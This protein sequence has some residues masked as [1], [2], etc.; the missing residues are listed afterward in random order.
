MSRFGNILQTQI[1]RQVLGDEH[2]GGIHAGFVDGAGVKH[3]RIIRLVVFTHQPLDF[4]GAY[5]VC[6]HPLIVI[7]ARHPCSV[8]KQQL[9]QFLFSAFCPLRNP[10]RLFLSTQL[11]I[12]QAI[13]R[14]PGQYCTCLFIDYP[15]GMK[16]D[17]TYGQGRPSPIFLGI[18]RLNSCF[19][20]IASI[21]FLFFS[22][23]STNSNPTL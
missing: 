11:P 10:K 4:L 16:Y 22:V 17:G 9:S 18:L 1:L 19:S 13:M 14:K 7:V 6:Q 3:R 15:G 21:V 5:L 23:M 2:D 20:R 12:C 8:Q